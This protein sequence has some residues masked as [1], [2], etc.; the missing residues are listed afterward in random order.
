MRDARRAVERL[1]SIGTSNI[2]AVKGNAL[3]EPPCTSG[4]R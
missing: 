3:H 1:Y 4:G 2:P